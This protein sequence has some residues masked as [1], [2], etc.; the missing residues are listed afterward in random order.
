MF[1]IPVLCLIS[2]FRIL[3][4]LFISSIAL[5]ML[6]YTTRNLFADFFI[7]IRVSAPH[8]FTGNTHCFYII[9]FK[10]GPGQ[11]PL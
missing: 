9:P 4:F 8:V 6:R 7:S 1:F 2:A 11:I 10:G 3:F 5:S